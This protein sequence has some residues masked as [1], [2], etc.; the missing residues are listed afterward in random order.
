M[1]KMPEIFQAVLSQWD[2]ERKKVDGHI[3]HAS[4]GTCRQRDEKQ[5]GRLVM[6]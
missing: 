4:F 1:W 6:T 2:Y 3:A 5:N